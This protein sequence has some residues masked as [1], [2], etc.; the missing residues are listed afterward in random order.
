M[1]IQKAWP[2]GANQELLYEQL[3]AQFPSLTTRPNSIEIHNITAQD[4][5]AI[6]AIIAAHVGSALT[7]G[8]KITQAQAIA[9]NQA[10]DYLRKQLMQANPNVSIIY[11]QIKVYIDNHAVLA[12]MVTNQIELM[13]L[14]YAWPILGILTNTDKSRYIMAVQHVIALLG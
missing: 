2:N 6:D 7:D 3:R 14:A 8:Q 11:T 5:S 12:Q 10:R 4:E 13:R 9:L 1:D